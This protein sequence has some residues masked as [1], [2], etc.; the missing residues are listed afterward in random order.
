[1]RIR[2]V[3]QDKIVVKNTGY[4][5]DGYPECDYCISNFQ[6]APS[7]EVRLDAGWVP[8]RPGRDFNP[9]VGEQ[10]D[11]AN[12][13]GQYKVT[14]ASA[15]KGTQQNLATGFK[16]ELRVPDVTWG[17][18]TIATHAPP[19][20]A[21]DLTRAS[22]QPTDD[23]E[24]SRENLPNFAV[25]MVQKALRGN[26]PYVEAL[27]DEFRRVVPESTLTRLAREAEFEVAFSDNWVDTLEEMLLSRGITSEED[28]GLLL[29]T[30]QDGTRVVSLTDQD[31]TWVPAMF[32]LRVTFQGWKRLQSLVSGFR[33]EL[34]LWRP[35]TIY[36][37]CNEDDEIVRVWWN[38]VAECD[39]RSYEE[40]RE[41]FQWCT[42]WASAPTTSW[43]FQICVVDDPSYLTPGK[44]R[45]PS[46]ILCMSDSSGSGSQG[47]KTP[48]LN[49]PRY[50][51]RWELAAAEAE[52][53]QPFEPGV[54]FV[55]VQ[56]FEC[57]LGQ[58]TFSSDEEGTVDGRVLRYVSAQAMLTQ[59]MWWA[60][61][62]GQNMD[63]L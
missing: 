43:K 61:R 50:E 17:K 46:M 59:K 11:F 2:I 16:R 21:P 40:L 30:E 36:R 34:D 55:A 5:G 7:W 4:P 20:S 48:T 52:D 27:T 63:A 6:K 18:D 32:P 35:K 23:A 8:F 62:G 42:G 56:D 3:L 19:P 24:L 49:L 29:V 47:V 25:A 37:L 58:V 15:T 60:V 26:L 10:F 12:A 9:R 39:A 51:G 38:F 44:E 14:L 22:S 53:W 45:L 33:V 13:H 1:M 28:R 57:E 41:L 54:S 31:R